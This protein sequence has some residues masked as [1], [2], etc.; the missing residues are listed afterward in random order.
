MGSKVHADTSWLIALFDSEDVNHG[1]AVREFEELTVLPTISAI[2]L[3]EIMINFDGRDFPVTK[4]QL[5]EALPQVVDISSDIA[6]LAAQ[7]KSTSK[8]NLGDAT[9]IATAL[10]TKSDLLTFDKS[11]KALYERNK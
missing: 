2:T 8:V 1:R 9:I 4:I 6:I 10:K 5:Q 7:L 3:A 11:M